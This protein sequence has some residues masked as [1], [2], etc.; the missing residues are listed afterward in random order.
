VAVKKFIAK[1]N[2][3]IFFFERENIF[4]KIFKRKKVF[5]ENVSNA[6]KVFSGKC[7]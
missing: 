4:R 2:P 1:K 7:F 3:G 6:K 5:S